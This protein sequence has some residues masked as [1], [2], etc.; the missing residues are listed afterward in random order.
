MQGIVDTLENLWAVFVGWLDSFFSFMWDV[1][2][3]LL[4]WAFESALGVA[5]V[6]FT[7]LMTLIGSWNTITLNS[8]LLLM[9]PD[10]ATALFYIGIPDAIALLSVAWSYRLIKDFLISVVP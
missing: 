10:V 3:D 8:L 4:L 1:G 6:A 2:R 7:S 9:P 5:D